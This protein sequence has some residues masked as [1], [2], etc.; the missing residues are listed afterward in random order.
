MPFNFENDAIPEANNISTE[1]LNKIARKNILDLFNKNC[2]DE[3]LLHL[4]L[5]RYLLRR[6]LILRTNVLHSSVINNL[7]KLSPVLR[8]AIIYI[9][10]TTKSSDLQLTGNALVSF[11][12]Q[13]DLAYLPFISLWIT[14]ALTDKFAKDCEAETHNICKSVRDNLGTRPFAIL[15]KKLK[16]LDWVRQQ[17]E[18]WQNNNPWDRRA[19]IWSA[20][21]LSQD[22]RKYWLMRVQNAGDILDK[23]IA[24]A[25]MN[26]TE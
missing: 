26:I 17:K 5:A 11:F 4:G 20:S 12:N 22:E 18:T 10:K 1:E 13:S 16:Y 19:I 2:L 24:T 23:A 15:A 7:D 8:D 6:S 21:A 9:T 25:A 14:H 3:N